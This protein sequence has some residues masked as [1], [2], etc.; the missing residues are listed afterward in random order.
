MIRVSEEVKKKLD[1][2][3]HPGQTYDGVLRE[4]LEKV[5]MQEHKIY[6]EAWRRLYLY[7]VERFDDQHLDL[8]EGILEAT[9]T[10]LTST[11]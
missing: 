2:L 4:L 9:K 10:D 11:A 6:E 7:F 8:M 1:Q 5:G 3:R